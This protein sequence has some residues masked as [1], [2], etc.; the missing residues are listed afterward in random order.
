MRRLSLFFGLGISLLVLLVSGCIQIKEPVACTDDA[1]A[2]PD[3]TYVG[4][5]SNNNCQF[6]PCPQ[7]RQCTEEVKNCPGASAV[8]RDPY[9]NCEFYPCPTIQACTKELKSCPGGT[10]VSRNPSNNC[11]FY[12]CPPT[13][14]ITK[15][16]CE[17]QNGIVVLN[18]GAGVM[19]PQGRVMIGT[20]NIGVESGICCR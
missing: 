14:K 13:T 2:C 3:G 1:K 12:E 5:D 4:R 10:M 6:Y 16:K 11:E 17:S 9:N 7:P 15:I 18:P 20:V 8:G 19:C